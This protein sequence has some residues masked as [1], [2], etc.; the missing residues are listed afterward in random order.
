LDWGRKFPEAKY[1]RRPKQV[2]HTF[3]IKEFVKNQKKKKLLEMMNAADRG[4]AP[5]GMEGGNPLGA[6]RP[7]KMPVEMER[8]SLPNRETR[9]PDFLTRREESK[10][11]DAD[12][13]A[14][15]NKKT[16]FEELLSKRE[17]SLPKKEEKLPNIEEELSKPLF[18]EEDLKPTKQEEPEKEEEDDDLGFDV[19]ELVKKIDAKI[20]EL[21]EEERRVKEEEKAQAEK[22]EPK[23]TI[24][25]SIKEEKNSINEIHQEKERVAPQPVNLSLDDESEDDD[26]FFDDFFDN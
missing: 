10:E 13:F 16:S 2:V 24:D 3:D 22:E 15:K 7:E 1:P 11:I 4:E 23:V 21:E 9:I 12:I 26:D 20:A 25:A 8:P 18:L 19:D 5:S 17:A 6:I 14:S